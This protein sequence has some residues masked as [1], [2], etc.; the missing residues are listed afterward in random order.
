PQVLL[1][2]VEHPLPSGPL[3][4]DPVENGAVEPEVL[5]VEATA[6]FGRI[7]VY[8]VP[9]QIGLPI[10]DGVTAEGGLH[11]QEELRLANHH[12]VYLRH[13]AIRQMLAPP[14]RR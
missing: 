5:R 13:S 12:P 6:G 3:F 9:S 1:L 2:E 10:L 14:D 11:L 4:R 8:E 7:R